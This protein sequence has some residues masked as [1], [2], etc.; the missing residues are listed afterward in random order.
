MILK[1]GSK[2]NIGLNVVKMR[3]DGFHLIESLFYP[4][5]SLY[6]LVE[7]VKSDEKEIRFSQ[8]GIFINCPT[9]SNLCV[10]AYRVFASHYKIGSVKIHLHKKIPFGAGLGGGSANS[11]AVLIILNKIFN[12]NAT[13]DELCNIAREIG[14]DVPFFIYNTP[15][16]ARGTGDV[17][18]PSTVDLSGKYLTIIKPSFGVA[19]EK[20]YSLITPKES[21]YLLEKSL[22]RDIRFWRDEVT[23]DFES[24]IFVLNPCMRELK[25]M[26]YNFGAEYVSMSGSGSAIYSISSLS[27]DIE[28]FKHALS[29]MDATL[30]HSDTITKLN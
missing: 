16:I 27:Y 11:A 22:S 26:L 7:V 1:S 4:V 13:Q 19:T 28:E 15:L 6:D 9:E 25:N 2:I 8:S 23:N 20:A 30:I 12:I 10:K 14:S 29:E 21:K 18:T 5:N 3:E 24:P 17:F